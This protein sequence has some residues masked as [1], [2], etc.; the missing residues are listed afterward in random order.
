MISESCMNLNEISAC[1]IAF[2]V[3][4]IKSLVDLQKYAS[5]T[6]GPVLF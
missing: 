6:T 5:G 1:Q 3:I 4:E 2:C